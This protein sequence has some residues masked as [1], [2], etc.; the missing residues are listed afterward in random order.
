MTNVDRRT[1][2]LAYSLKRNKKSIASSQITWEMICGKSCRETQKRKEEDDF[3]VLDMTEGNNEDVREEGVQRYMP[4][5]MDEPVHD[6]QESRNATVKNLPQPIVDVIKRF[7]IHL[8]GLNSNIYSKISL[9]DIEVM[10][11]S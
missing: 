3:E 8:F 5:G 2:T 11:N 6:R 7:F 9:T 4:D 10:D 1:K